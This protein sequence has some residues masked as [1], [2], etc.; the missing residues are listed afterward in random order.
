MD[1]FN[2]LST[3]AKILTVFVVMAVIAG[4]FYFL[5]ISDVEAQI[6]SAEAQRK[7]AEAEAAQLGQQTPASELERLKA[8]EKELKE[9]LERNKELLPRK[10]ELPRLIASIKGK[11]DELGL[12]IL[13]FVKNDRQLEDY[14]A[15]IPVQM[16]VEATF[17]VLIAFFDALADEGMRMMTVTDIDLNILPIKRFIPEQE[18]D[19]R[20]ERR[21]NL[22][23]DDVRRAAMAELIARLDAYDAGLKRAKIAASFTVNAFSYTGKLLS[24]EERK[25]RA[26]A[27]RK[28]SRKKK[29]RRR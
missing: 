23:P 6:T 17:P 5:L 18:K 16:E 22:T 4:G 2:D 15:K 26:R 11:A 9:R 14:I 7:A 13:R 21:R 25:K 1:R 29:R 3:P 28:K 12:K 27:A 19:N 8:D 24:A 10:E 20:R